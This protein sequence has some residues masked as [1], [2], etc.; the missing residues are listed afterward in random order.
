MASP[1]AASLGLKPVSLQTLPPLS[2]SP[3]SGFFLSSVRSLVCQ[4]GGY[5][6]QVLQVMVCRE[7][8]LRSNEM[9]SPWCSPWG[10]EGLLYH[11]CIR[12]QPHPIWSEF[13]RLFSHI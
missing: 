13:P 10:K 9:G 3:S 8:A 5:C 11:P 7:G 12:K 1:E 2:A 4:K 6:K